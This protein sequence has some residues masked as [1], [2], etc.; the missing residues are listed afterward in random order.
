[1]K[2][3]T[4]F[5]FFIIYLLHS[6]RSNAQYTFDQC[7]YSKF[8]DITNGYC[9]EYGE[10]SNVGATSDPY[11]SNG[12]S[13]SIAFENG[14]WFSFTPTQSA[15][16]IRVLG[17][18]YGGTMSDPKILI[19]NDCDDYLN[20]TSG[21]DNIAELITDKLLIGKNYYIMVES[22]IGGEGSFQICIED[23]TPVPSPQSD[24]KE[25]VV[26]CDK[27]SFIVQ[28][29]NS[30]GDDRNEI[31][32]GNCM[33]NEA[34]PS[35]SEK[36]STWYKWICDKSGS[37][38][39][40]LT[41]NDYINN[42]KVTVDL[43]F[44]IYELPKGID[45][46][47]EKV[48]LRCMAS[49]ANV[50]NNKQVLPLS[51]W[52]SCN[53]KTGLRNTESDLSESPGCTGNSNNF[54]SPLDMQS[55]KAYVL[56]VNN[57]SNNGIG[58][59]I[60]FGGSGTFLGPEAD[61]EV[62]ALQEF[63]CDKTIRFT[64]KSKSQTDEITDY[65]WNFGNGANPNASTQVGPLD[66]IYD[67]FGDKVV[68]LTIN[69]SRGCQVTKLLPIFVE[70]CCSDFSLKVNGEKTEP[71]CTNDN[72]GT[73]LGKGTAGNPPYMFSIT[74]NNFQTVPVF[75]DLK[76][77]NYY[78]Y[79]QD[80]KG[81]RDSILIELIDPLP[82]EV[83]AGPDKTIEL[84]EST[85][86]DGSYSPPE[87]DV[88]HFWTP[89]YNL[90]DSSDLVPDANPYKTTK[91]TLTV[92]QDETGCTATDEMT[93]FVTKNRKIRI[94]NVFTPNDDGKNDS[95]IAY[96][97]K[98]AIKIDEMLVFDRWGELLFIEKDIELGDEQRG[99]DGRFKDQKVNPGVYVYLFKIKF[100][101]GEIVP[102]SGDITV[103]R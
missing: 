60:D 41:P 64:N 1:M 91:Y 3:K 28:Q 14:V 58:F 50:D 80:K 8:I 90:S 24:C 61:F 40:T 68:A 21:G 13:A 63:E 46:C 83:N 76:A 32:P 23:F 66:V 26:L 2:K 51:E 31:E 37:L 77:G 42:S 4:I 72:N 75:Y 33:Y 102:F 5:L 101:D 25:G 99:W 70:S 38:T 29:L 48:L 84:S 39:F 43:D 53:G 10:F 59:K 67:S 97:V 34:N 71:I 94:P 74:G 69:S 85:T 54:I 47:S 35:S 86:L 95:F 82:L 12:C 20:C 11:F 30:A 17:K 55:G 57:Y 88:T 7:Q 44:A 62:E 56:I 19:F 100:L 52:A 92:V 81:C 36:G 93:V 98:A 87:Y 96:N 18:G 22:A 79:I 103:L 27:S 45:D 16:S 65:F 15:I 73:I 78:L 6:N 49:G 9:S 89:N